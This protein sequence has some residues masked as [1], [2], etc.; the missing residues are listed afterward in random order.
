LERNKYKNVDRN[1]EFISPS[2]IAI[3]GDIKINGYNF[4]IM[5]CDEYST[6]YLATNTY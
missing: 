2:D 3:G 6:K 5:G 1:M 4:H